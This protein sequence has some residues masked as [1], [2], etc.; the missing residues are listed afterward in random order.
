MGAAIV[1]ATS[2]EGSVVYTQLQWG[3]QQAHFPA[4]QKRMY[5]LSDLKKVIRA[6]RQRQEQEEQSTT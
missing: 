1:W 2:W 6:A 5:T 3:E 4:D